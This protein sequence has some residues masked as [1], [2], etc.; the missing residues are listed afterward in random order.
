MT[1]YKNKLKNINYSKLSGFWN[2][3]A[4]RVQG[5]YSVNYLMD[6][7]HELIA[8]H[9]F[10]KDLKFI[11][12][13][14]P[15]N[16]EGLLD[17]G[18][19]TGN[20]LEKLA[21]L[22][23]YSEGIDFSRLS[24]NIAKQKFKNIKNIKIRCENVIQTKLKKNFDLINVSEVLMY[25]DNEDVVSLLK[26]TNNHLNKNGLIT[27]RESIASNKTVNLDVGEHKTIRRT[28]S[29][30]YKLFSEAGLKV[31]KVE[32]NYDYNY[33]WI[34]ALTFNF[35]P[36][37]LRNKLFLNFYLNNIITRFFLLFI[38][39]KIMT[40]FKPNSFLHYYFVLNK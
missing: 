13:N 24:I 10:V 7:K 40:F 1:H 39:V 25:L 27:L 11:I 20:Y 5:K 35:F 33:A 37:L 12:S 8:R 18:C 23:S 15:Q 29:E 38:P 3:L 21:P 14:L 28:I 36:S 6:K 34:S 9:R 16:R 22:F 4:P 30:F 2:N 17:L 26:K 19:G 31:T 32:Q